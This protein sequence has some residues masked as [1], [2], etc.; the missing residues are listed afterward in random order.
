MHSSAD[1]PTANPRR[2]VREP[3]PVIGV[4]FA[5]GRVYLAMQ[6]GR[7]IGAPLAQF[8]RLANATDEQRSHWQRIGRGLGIHWPDVDE[9]LSV[10]HLLGLS[11]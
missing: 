4:R 2:V 10:A 11:D 9:D 7:E 6:D 5:E 8:P 1:V 3:T